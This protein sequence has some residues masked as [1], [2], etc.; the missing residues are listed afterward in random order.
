MKSALITGSSKGIGQALAL[1]LA[2]QG[3][4]VAVHGIEPLDEIE[5][6]AE[7]VR[8]LG[9]RAVP[10]S[11]NLAE[12][13]GAQT[14][15]TQAIAFLEKIDILILCAAVQ[16][17]KVWTE[18]TADEFDL[19][20][21]VNLHSGFELLQLA[22]PDM[23]ARG[24]GRVITVGS[25]QQQKPHPHMF[26][27]AATK[28]AQLNIAYNLAREIAPYGVTVNNLRVGVIQTERNQAVL[29]DPA[30]FQRVINAIPAGNLGEPQDCVGVVQILCSEAGRYITGAD[31][32][33]D[34]GMHLA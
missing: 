18:I 5:P 1:G 13:H 29:A 28:S 24:W 33:I 22:V 16:I 8:A 14:L 11:V 30:Q 12:K 4:S 3:V 19:Q 7:Q 15:Y 20:V 6:V 27:Y 31:I 21:Q 9:V 34:G 10:L 2:Q 25:I 26:I 17:R 23:I 32:P